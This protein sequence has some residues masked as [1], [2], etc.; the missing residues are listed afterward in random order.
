MV[1][2]TRNSASDAD[3]MEKS[4]STFA[5]EMATSAMIL[6]EVEEFASSRTGMATPQ[7]LI[8][9]DEVSHK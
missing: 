1:R 4:I 8:L 3:S 2:N 7:S 5:A 9:I 6:G